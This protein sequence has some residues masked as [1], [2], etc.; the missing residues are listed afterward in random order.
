MRLGGQ[1]ECK[2]SGHCS[3]RYG[4]LQMGGTLY[5]NDSLTLIHYFHLIN[6][7]FR[8]LTTRNLSFLGIIDQLEGLCISVSLLHARKSGGQRTFISGHHRGII[9]A[10]RHVFPL[11]GIFLVLNFPHHRYTVIPY[12]MM[13][14]RYQK[15][16]RMK[17]RFGSSC[18]MRRLR[19]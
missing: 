11:P 6:N 9:S 16:E 12:S 1:G 19:V 13:I 5:S 15:R 7:K 8:I 10:N 18:E 17:S 3:K 4:F 14:T 2:K